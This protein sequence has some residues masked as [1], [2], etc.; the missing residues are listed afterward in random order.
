ME[1]LLV[2]PEFMPFFDMNAEKSE[3][4]GRSPVLTRGK[5]VACWPLHPQSPCPLFC[6][7]R[8]PTWSLFWYLCCEGS[9]IKFGFM[10][11]EDGTSRDLKWQRERPARPMLLDTLGVRL[12]S[13][14]EI[15]STHMRMPW[16]SSLIFT[17][18]NDTLCYVCDRPL[19]MKILIDWA[20]SMLLGFVWNCASSL[21][22]GI[23]W[24]ILE[25]SSIWRERKLVYLYESTRM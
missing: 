3:L 20:S 1:G 5:F 18:R 22:V 8:G 7:D 16:S 12:A 4:V 19:V 11:P 25:I 24:P 17:W 23:R 14:F 9:I 2:L 15:F 21:L 10:W 6:N 13:W